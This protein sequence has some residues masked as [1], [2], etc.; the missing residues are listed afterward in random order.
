MILVGL[1][2]ENSELGR[3]LLLFFSF[4]CCDEEG[5]RGLSS[6]FIIS[7]RAGND[8]EK[9]RVRNLFFDKN[10]RINSYCYDVP[11]AVIQSASLRAY[12]YK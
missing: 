3:K 12:K 4:S 10:E 2:N 8:R 7:P 11:L 5:K 9:K 1:K 6:P